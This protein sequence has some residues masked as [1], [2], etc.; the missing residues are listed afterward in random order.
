[1]ADTYRIDPGQRHHPAYA[2][3]GKGRWR[4]EDA[5]QRALTRMRQDGR[6]SWD[7]TVRPYRCTAIGKPHWHLGHSQ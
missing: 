7:W 5:A 4:T 3:V 2:C 1:M 6:G